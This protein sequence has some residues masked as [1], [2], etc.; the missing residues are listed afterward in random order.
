MLKGEK[1]L[2]SRVLFV[3]GFRRD[4]EFQVPGCRFQVSTSSL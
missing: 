3:K 4:V 2:G 1:V